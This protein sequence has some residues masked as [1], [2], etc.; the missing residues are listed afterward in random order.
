[1]M[2]ERD[3][4]RVRNKESGRKWNGKEDENKLSRHGS[5]LPCHKR[6]GGELEKGKENE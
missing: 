1:M 3:E 5:D 4:E 6:K 2:S